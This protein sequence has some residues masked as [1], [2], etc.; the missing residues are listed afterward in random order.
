MG[1]VV[2]ATMYT[3]VNDLQTTTTATSLPAGGVGRD[4]GHIL[5]AADLH[6]R[7]GQSAQRRLG[8]GTGGLG[9]VATGGTELD[10][11]GG[12]AQRLA[13]LGDVLCDPNEGGR[14]KNV[15]IFGI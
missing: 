10:V 2:L 1:F 5:D 9:L 6:R 3:V 4:R 12:D 15:L 14:E 7:T 13:L 8:S 11:Q